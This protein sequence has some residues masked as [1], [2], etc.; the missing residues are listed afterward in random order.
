VSN[1]KSQIE[2]YENIQSEIQANK[3]TENKDCVVLDNTNIKNSLV[4]IMIQWQTSLLN[5]IQEK[6]LSDLNKYYHLFSSSATDLGVSPNDLHALKRNHDLLNKLMDEKPNEEKKLGPLE[7][8]FKLL[9]DYSINLKEEDI[10]KKSQIKL[11]WAN[12][13]QMLE[14]IKKRNEKVSTELYHETMKGLDDFMKETSD[15][16][17]LFIGNAPYSSNNIQSEKAFQILLDYKEQVKLLRKREDQMKFGVD[18]FK[19]SYV[20]SPDIEFVEKEM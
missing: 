1:L 9:D 3:T 12:Y 2:Q 8:K 4:N 10:L 16:K 20:P 7:D 18:L 19:I 15:N 11:E 17:A 14:R 13:C 5:T 6:A